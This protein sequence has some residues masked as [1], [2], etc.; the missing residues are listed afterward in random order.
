M[1]ETPTIL[2]TG[3]SRGI[4]FET[5]RLLA[6]RG[7]TLILH[8]RSREEGEESYNRLVSSGV[9][10]RRLHPAVAD[11]AD[12][13]QVADLAHTIDELY[14]RLDVLVNNAATAGEASRVITKDGHERTWQVNYLAPY[15]LTRLLEDAL[16]RSETGRVVNVSSSLHR[17]GRI[18]WNDLNWK[19]RYSR[20]AAYTQSK[21]ALTML[22]TA[23]TELRPKVRE[24]VSVHPG[25]I[26]TAMLP[27][28]SYRGRPAA[29]GAEPVARLADPGLK[30]LDG[31][32]YDG[33]LPAKAAAAAVDPDDVRKLWNFSE[34]LV[35]LDKRKR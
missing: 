10:S 5:T 33:R 9:D 2:L 34:R 15:L 31:G 4:G 12:L 26:A 1:N 23:L 13:Q 8:A 30:V 11:F 19:R 3:T 16:N 7:C 22:T 17:A 27:T 25:V 14:P 6:A 24:S 28:Y 20:S 35:L 29:E 32:Y 18:N 21:L